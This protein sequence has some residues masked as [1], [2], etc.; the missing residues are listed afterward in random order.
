MKPYAAPP[1]PP[2][3]QLVL[4]LALSAGCCVPTAAKALR[5]GTAKI[6]GFTLR[7]RIAAGAATLG[8]TLPTS[9]PSEA[10]K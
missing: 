1:P 9:P 10:S 8:I 4:A 5:E 3:P 2:N 6:K 7:E